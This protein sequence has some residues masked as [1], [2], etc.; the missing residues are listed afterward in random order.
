MRR[1]LIAVLVLFAFASPA[2]AQN[3]QVYFRMR[4]NF[5]GSTSVDSFDMGGWLRW[6]TSAATPTVSAAGEAR[7]YF[8]GTVMKISQNGG[9]YTNLVATG[10]GS[11]TVTSVGLSLTGGIFTVSGSPVTT[12]GTL[13]G[14]LANQTGN[15]IFA[16]PAAGTSGTPLFRSMVLADIP[17]SLI[18]FGKWA[19]NGCS[20]NDIPKWS[21][22]AW[23]C[24]T[25]TG[26]SATIYL[27]A[28]WTASQAEQPATNYASFVVRNNHPAVAFDAATAETVYFSGVIPDW[29]DNTSAVD[30]VVYWTAATATTGNVV[31]K[32]AWE[33]NDG[34]L[35]IDVDSFGTDISTTTTTGT[36]SGWTKTSVMSFT[37][38]QADNLTT[39]PIRIR[40]TR[41][42]ANASDTMA[43]DAQVLMVQVRKP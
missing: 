9:A 24:G 23:A 41:D 11:G 31:W 6:R 2:L 17:N 3:Q 36:T 19:S 16:S 14:T 25:D 43:G 32:C 40:V 42:A 38:A 22:S 8:D 20:T 21:G 30:I 35:D 26:G 12:T 27:L 13:T 4:I 1:I 29:Y 37:R 18:T 39:G 10:G 5:D 28:Q 34:L 33:N 15:T 7:L